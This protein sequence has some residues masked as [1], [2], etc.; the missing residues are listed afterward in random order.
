MF[1]TVQPGK[2]NFFP[3]LV[4]FT[5]Q[6]YTLLIQK[7]NH[8][9]GSYYCRISL[10]HSQSTL[11][12][13]IGPSSG[14]LLHKNGWCQTPLRIFYLPSGPCPTFSSAHEITH[15]LNLAD[16]SCLQ[17]H[18]L[19]SLPTKTNSLSSILPQGQFLELLVSFELIALRARCHIFM[20]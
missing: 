17:V 20:P 18:S 10:S 7:S 2:I 6:M 8:Y 3:C 19:M 1:W 16:S 14:L 13:G 4:S 12:P 5:G 9:Y 11:A 15:P